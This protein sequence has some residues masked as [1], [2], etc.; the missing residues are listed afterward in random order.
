LTTGVTLVV[1]SNNIV[2]NRCYLLHAKLGLIVCSFPYFV[3]IEGSEEEKGKKS[4][5]L[6]S[7]KIDYL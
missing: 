5:A 7:F 3:L 1:D 2:D 6:M 4:F